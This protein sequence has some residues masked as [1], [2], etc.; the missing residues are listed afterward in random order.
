[1]KIIYLDF[2]ATQFSFDII[3]IGAVKYTGETFYTLVKPPKV[4]KITPLITKITGLTK[5]MFDDTLQ[6]ICS[7]FLKF[8]NWCKDGCE[9]E[10][11]LFVTYGGF[12]IT[13]LKHCVKRFPNVPEFEYVLNNVQ[14]IQSILNKLAGFSTYSL[15]SLSKLYE[16]CFEKEPE[17]LHNSLCDAQMLQEVHKSVQN[18]SLE[19][20]KVLAENEVLNKYIKRYKRNRKRVRQDIREYLDTLSDFEI[21]TLCIEDLFK[22][23]LYVCDEVEGIIKNY[24]FL[25][26]GTKLKGQIYER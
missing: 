4:S 10:D 22:A 21:D 19:S 3:S 8:V 15:A 2:E 1:M 11:I 6:P 13:L 14:D 25:L 7:I 18:M 20:L 12:D 5:E 24:Y 23:S 26:K 17:G 9:N 16:T